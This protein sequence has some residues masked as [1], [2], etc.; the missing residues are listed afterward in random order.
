MI[1]INQLAE[2]LSHMFRFKEDIQKIVFNEEIV[3]DDVRDMFWKAGMEIDDYHFK[4]LDYYMNS[5]ADALE[6]KGPLDIE[7]LHEE[8]REAI[9]A[10]IYTSDLTEWLNSKNSRVYYLTEALEELDV[11]NGFHLLSYAQFLEIEE[12]YQMGLE[13]IRNYIEYMGGLEDSQ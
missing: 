2:N 4:W 7:S 1:T 8:L 5:F 3:N 11:K 9:E 12:V 13:V 10:D 6:D